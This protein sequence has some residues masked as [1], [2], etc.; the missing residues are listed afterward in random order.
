MSPSRLLLSPVL[1]GIAL[2]ATGTV[3]AACGGG[4]EGG[5]TATP[6]ATAVGTPRATG[7]PAPGAAATP[8]AQGVIEIQMG[9]NFNKPNK[10][11]VEA[12]QAV[13]LR[14]TNKGQ[15]IHNARLAGADNGYNTGDD[16]VTE[17]NMIQPGESAELA[18]KLD[19]PGVYNFKCD[20]HPEATGQITV[21]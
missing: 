20:F 21:Q 3:A 6:R 4:E 5:T 1:V 2:L 8:D 16:V 14:F 11:S 12:G 10:L 19:K 18:F 9:D 15:A 7:T 13:T 17:P